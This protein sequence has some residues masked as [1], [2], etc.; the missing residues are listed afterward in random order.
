MLQEKN[1][2][3]NSEDVDLRNVVSKDIP[4]Y[5]CGRRSSFDEVKHV[6]LC[7]RGPYTYMADLVTDD[8]GK[9]IKICY[10]IV[11]C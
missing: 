3:T 1:K 11:D 2:R 4:I 8:N 7:E 9:I 5:L 10:D 6:Q